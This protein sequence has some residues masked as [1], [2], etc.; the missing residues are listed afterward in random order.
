MHRSVS[1]SDFWRVQHFTAIVR[2]GPSSRS[3]DYR[4]VGWG[5]GKGVCEWESMECV[6]V[7]ERVKERGVGEGG[8]VCECE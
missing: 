8:R 4:R 5:E 2:L 3:V 6:R 1:Y 7:R